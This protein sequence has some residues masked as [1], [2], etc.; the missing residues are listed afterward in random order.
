MSAMDRRLRRE[1]KELKKKTCPD[2]VIRAVY[3]RIGDG[4]QS[5]FTGQSSRYLP[6]RWIRYFSWA[7]APVC[8]ILLIVLLTTHSPIKFQKDSCT[9]VYSSHEIAQADQQIKST[10]AL[11]HRVSHRTCSRIRNNTLSGYVSVPVSRALC[12]VFN[13]LSGGNNHE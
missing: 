8:I 13:D 6:R 5:R 12:L 1:F 3:D 11:I 10:L 7:A 4:M 2:E 9:P